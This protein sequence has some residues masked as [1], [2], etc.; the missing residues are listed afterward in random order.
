MLVALV[1][2]THM[3]ARG[4][5]LLFND[6][7]FQFWNGVFFPYL[8]KH[9]IK[10]VFHLGDLVDKRKS[11]NYVILNTWNKKYF[12][13]MEDNGI[14][15]ECIV[16]NHDVPYKNTNEVDA[17]TE[18]FK[19]KYPNI[20]VH[21][22]PTEVNFDG[23][24]VL[25]LPWIN[26]ENMN[27]SMSLIK[28]TKAQI[29]FG[30]L[31]IAGFEFDRGNMCHD[32][33]DRSLFKKFDRVLSG[34]FHHK[35]SDGTIDYLGC[36]YEMTWQDYGDPKGF[37]VFDTKT[38]KL[39]YIQN[40]YKMFYK[41]VYDEEELYLPKEEEIAKK[42]VK[43]IV[44][45]RKDNDKFDEYVTRIEKFG[46]ADLNFIESDFGVEIQLSDKIDESKSTID[47]L[48]DYVKSRPDDGV[49]NSDVEKLL[50]E[51][52]LESQKMETE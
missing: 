8:K 4:D 23:T 34:H 13:Y 25:L 50:K 9:D 42:H 36:Q 43:I 52:Y 21:T 1:N 51:L 44:R 26:S 18:L 7:F 37:H 38:R 24:N 40:P 41:H 27:E 39:E 29:V 35:S 48:V 12:K 16:G 15:F 5:N 14:D 47:I 45:N 10:K 49:A 33:L 32:G 6:Y 3:G 31:E 11:I 20:I 19:K 28:T 30:H 17:I 22:K 2:D 46:P